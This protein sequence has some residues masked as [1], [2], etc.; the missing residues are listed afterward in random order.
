MENF[1]QTYGRC[2]IR[3]KDK[4]KYLTIMTKEDLGKLSSRDENSFYL[5]LTSEKKKAAKWEF[6]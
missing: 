6:I 1:P 3:L 5:I 2:L 4:K